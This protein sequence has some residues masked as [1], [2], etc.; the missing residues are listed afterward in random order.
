MTKEFDSIEIL[1]VAPANP[2]GED[3][4]IPKVV[5]FQMDYYQVDNTLKRLISVGMDFDSIEALS[6]DE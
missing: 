4:E 6:E 2:G 1:P 3:G 5:M